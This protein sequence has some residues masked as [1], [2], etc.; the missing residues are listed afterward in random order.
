MIGETS[1]ADRRGGRD[2]SGRDASRGLPHRGAPAGDRLS[3]ID[4]CRAVGAARAS[5][6]A[7]D[8]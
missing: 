2:A 3:V 8:T 4:V 7:N 6:E 1:S 5:L